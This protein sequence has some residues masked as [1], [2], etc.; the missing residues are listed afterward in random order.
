[1]SASAEAVEGTCDAYRLAD[2]R[3]NVLANDVS[4]LCCRKV[5][6][7]PGPLIHE[8]VW[9]TRLDRHGVVMMIIIGGRCLSLYMLL[10]VVAVTATASRQRR[11]RFPCEPDE[12]L[13]PLSS[14]ERC[15]HSYNL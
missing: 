8:F 11:V 15:R 4:L 1:M 6:G 10:G 14:L 7:Q 3:F 13:G 5:K 12:I 9:F 2:H